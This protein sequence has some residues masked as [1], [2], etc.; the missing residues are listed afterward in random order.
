MIKFVSQAEGIVSSVFLNIKRKETE[1]VYDKIIDILPNKSFIES[2]G[3]R[4]HLIID[5]DIWPELLSLCY[6]AGLRD[7]TIGA[8]KANDELHAFFNTYIEGKNINITW[9]L[10]E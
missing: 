5:G 6:A 8:D 10:N 2:S 7:V 1:K 3:Q 4:V 9:K